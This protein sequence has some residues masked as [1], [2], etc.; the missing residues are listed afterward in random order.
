ERLRRLSVAVTYPS[1]VGK[2]PEWEMRFKPFLPFFMAFVPSVFLFY[3]TQRGG[4]K[5][6]WFPL[7]PP[8]FPLRRAAVCLRARRSQPGILPHPFPQPGKGPAD[9]RG[10][11]GS[12][13]GC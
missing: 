2:S 11:A 6:G 1:L 12:G 9:R 3:L 10:I 7:P 8:A 13:G 5:P 4:A